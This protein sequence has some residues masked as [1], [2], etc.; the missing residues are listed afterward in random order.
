MNEEKTILIGLS[1]AANSSVAAYI[2]QKQKM[3]VVGIF[4]ILTNEDE[5][6][7]SN[8]KA[9][10]RKL[11]IPFFSYDVREEYK[12]LVLSEDIA[13]RLSGEWEKLRYSK[14]RFICQ[15][16]FE[17]I[18]D[19]KA[20]HIATGHF[21]KIM[22]SL[23]SHEYVI[24]MIGERESDESRLLHGLDS[25]ILEKLVL[26]LGDLKK[27]D[28]KKLAD[29]FSLPT[30][31][32]SDFYHHGLDGVAPSLIKEAVWEF[33]DSELTM[34]PDRDGPFKLG[35]FVYKEYFVKTY[36]P[37]TGVYKLSKN[38]FEKISSFSIKKVHW[39]LTEFMNSSFT[40]WLKIEGEKELIESQVFIKNN[41]VLY[42]TPIDLEKILYRGQ[43]ITLYDKNAKHPRLIAQGEVKEYETVSENHPSFDL[44]F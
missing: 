30:L 9:I 14:A 18:A 34:Q 3:K 21:A 32:S 43:I 23:K 24:H 4:F 16:L 10:C 11:G 41:G 36:T 12:E 44:R 38:S 2:L 27:G 1:G 42:L 39:T 6:A 20:E 40:C 5:L 33:D 7:L 25:N 35:E 22:F 8:S 31:N 26:P 17:K 13:R 29:T 37:K 28:V 15:K 19:F